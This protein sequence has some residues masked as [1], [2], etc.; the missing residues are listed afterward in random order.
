MLVLLKNQSK[1]SLNKTGLDNFI[2][3]KLF[4]YLAPFAVLMTYFIPVM[5]EDRF[6]WFDDYYILSHLFNYDRGFMY[7][8]F[9]GEVISW[10]TDTVTPGVIKGTMIFGS[11][12]LLVA[13]TLCFGAVL[14]K[15]RDNR[16]VHQ[17]AMI[18]IA[19]LCI[20]PFTFKPYFVDM[21][22]D[23][24]FWAIALMA[25]LLCQKKLGIWFVPVLCMVA[26]LINPLFLMGSMLLV[27]IILLQKCY[28]SGFAVKNIVI[29][30]ISYIGMIALGVYAITSQTDIGFE[31]P[32]EMAEYYFKRYSEPI[33]PAVVEQ[34]SDTFLYEYFEEK[35]MDFFKKLFEVNFWGWERGK[36]IASNGLLIGVPAVSLFTAFWVKVIK[37]EKEKFQKF[38]F[39]LCA[40]TAAFAVAII[41][42]AWTLARNLA[43]NFIVQF[44]LILYF[45]ATKNEAVVTVTGRIRE[46]CKNNIV[47]SASVIAYFAIFIGEIY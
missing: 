12:M 33:D 36:T 4:C 28:E 7:K 44:G 23:K 45:L 21:K 34:V 38:I 11:V 30:A 37:E 27:A 26:T 15:T 31:T 29:C 18:I 41:P 22:F 19:F 14:S 2:H 42:I 10:F 39:F 16:E 1:I 25:V 40:A 5:A 43:H 24:L 46:F 6:E 35:N 20:A 47:L 17:A 3:S 8:G 9:V 13:G 32:Y